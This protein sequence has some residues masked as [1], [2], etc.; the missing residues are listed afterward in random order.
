[1]ASAAVYDEIADWYEQE[2]LPSTAAA[3]ADR[4]GIGAGLDTLLGWGRGIC[5]EIGCG[6]GVHASR[7][8][9]LGWTPF[10]IDLSAAMLRYASGRLPTCLRCGPTRC[11]CRPATAAFRPRSP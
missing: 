8:R 10:G 11:S 7:L 2:L 3:G 4:L 5:L 9:G 1:M 6:T